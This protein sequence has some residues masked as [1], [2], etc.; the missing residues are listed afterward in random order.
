[1]ESK[2]AHAWQQKYASGGGQQCTCVVHKRQQT[3]VDDFQKIKLILTEWVNTSDIYGLA[4][5]FFRK[6][7]TRTATPPGQR[8]LAEIGKT[9]LQVCICTH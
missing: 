8:L 2:K 5:N 7:D 9:G 4:G 6:L 1:M 3:T